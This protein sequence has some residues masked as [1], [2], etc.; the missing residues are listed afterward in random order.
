M[1]ATQT[2]YCSTC[3]SNL[4][5]RYSSDRDY[6]HKKCS[7]CVE[8]SW[9]ELRL[10]KFCR[11]LRLQHFFQCD[12][13][14]FG[15][16]LHATLN[17]D[18]NE[19]CIIDRAI[20][21]AV[22][23]YKD[24]LT[25]EKEI[26]TKGTEVLVIS[27][28]IEFR[29]GTKDGTRAVDIY[30]NVPTLDASSSIL[31]YESVFLLKIVHEKSVDMVQVCAPAVLPRLVTPPYFYTFVKMTWRGYAC[32]SFTAN[33]ELV[34][35]SEA[36]PAAVSWDLVREWLSTCR[37]EHA[38]CRMRPNVELPED[39]LLID[40]K[41]RRLVEG[42]PGRR[43][44]ALSYVWGPASSNSYVATTRKNLAA[45]KQGRYL[46]ASDIPPVINDAMQVCEKLGERYLWAD[47]LC[48]IQD[49]SDT[50]HRQIAAMDSIYS[51][52]T[53]VI[54]AAS[55]RSMDDHLAGVSVERLPMD[56]QEKMGELVIFTGLP[57]FQDAVSY[58]T[59]NER[60]WTYQE[61]ICARRKLYFSSTQVFFECNENTIS[62]DRRM[63]KRLRDARGQF[64]LRPLIEMKKSMSTTEEVEDRLY[65]RISDYDRHLRDYTSRSLT[66]GSDIYNAFAGITRAL[67]AP[68]HESF[69][70]MPL[71]HF[72]YAILY[73]SCA[74]EGPPQR[75]STDPLI[76][77]SWSWGHI[78]GVVGHLWDGSGQFYKYPRFFGSLCVWSSIDQSSSQ[79]RVRL[80]DSS[81]C[82][83]HWSD[84][85]PQSKCLTKSSRKDGPF[86]SKTMLNGF[87]IPLRPAEVFLALAYSDGLFET[88]FSYGKLET[89]SLDDF[90]ESW[91]TYAEFWRNVIAKEAITR[92]RE[93]TVRHH[94]PPNGSN[95]VA[96]TQIGT[97]QLR[98]HVHDYTC[99]T[100]FG[101]FAHGSCLEVLDRTGRDGIGLL[102]APVSMKQSNSALWLKD[103]GERHELIA[104]SLG[105]VDQYNH[106]RCL[107]KG[108]KQRI[109][110]G[111]NWMGLYSQM[112]PDLSSTIP[113]V[114]VMLISRYKGVAR[115]ES[116]GWVKMTEWI[117]ANR[118]FSN[119][120][121]D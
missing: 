107:Q 24:R 66:Y 2:L 26:K 4:Y 74:Q 113:V 84:D 110:F 1:L 30:A 22:A 17:F 18:P 29:K 88:P 55:T 58:T 98:V 11:H 42:R 80:I 46:S 61:V 118:K 95:L 87:N 93:S 48:V 63:W 49:D 31:R 45:L 70:G 81:G 43:F 82:E 75:R 56:T 12:I 41:R 79:Q 76:T 99:G 62:E 25:L 108:T 52:A 106:M 85:F 47:R 83:V 104:L 120:Y 35:I 32:G 6:F 15:H 119:I 73:V 69:Q 60:A 33:N 16:T 9:P 71:C 50:K 13:Q 89:I 5:R 21:K 64:R 53:L 102:H 91:P 40:V 97:F 7:T 27:M 101:T 67:Y 10:C 78:T 59:W 37:L 111:L 19:P 44:V 86:T 96:R 54:V 115:R 116:I 51:L 34:V 38:A 39:M 112:M 114:Y 57:S 100:G 65:F 68:D 8:N 109:R 72:D 20:V 23:A 28:E 94:E 14:G 3:R 121:F 92:Q 90:I 105:D 117:K 103:N 77:S 36:I